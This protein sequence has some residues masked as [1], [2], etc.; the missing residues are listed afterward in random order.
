MGGE[1]QWRVRTGRGCQRLLLPGRE[2]IGDAFRIKGQRPGT[3][4]ESSILKPVSVPGG[5]TTHRK[6]V[7]KG[8]AFLPSCLHR[9]MKEGAVSRVPSEHSPCAHTRTQ[10]PAVGLGRAFCN[11][12]FRGMSSRIPASTPPSLHSWV[13][14]NFR[15]SPYSLGALACL[16]L[17]WE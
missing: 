11:P 14:F 5:S 3:P 6:E 16:T 1:T 4:R 9:D 17:N 13:M 7:V 15:Q 12:H 10:I 2:R 8:R